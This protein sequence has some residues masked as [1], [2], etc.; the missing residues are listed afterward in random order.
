MASFLLGLSECAQPNR[1]RPE[2]HTFTH[3][4]PR[5]GFGLESEFILYARELPRLEVSA[6]PFFPARLSVVALEL[7]RI[8][9]RPACTYHCLGKK[10]D[11]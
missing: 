4:T 3:M 6:A 10:A 11:H 1:R 2:V 8:I 5:D 9:F 7:R